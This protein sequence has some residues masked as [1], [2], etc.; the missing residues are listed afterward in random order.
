M[1]E[2]IPGKAVTIKFTMKTHLPDGSMKERPEETT[3]FIFGVERQPVSLETALE[4]TR[5][6]DRVHVHIPP[7]EIYGDH[8]P[9]LIHEIPKK[10][11][12]SSRIKKGQF[13][14]QM[15]KGSLVSFKVLEV[16]ADTVLADFNRPM[17]GISAAVDVE[18][19]SVREASQKE[20][21]A[22]IDAQNK[23]GIGCG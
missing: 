12:I 19:L 15:K 20:I 21:D 23:R 22:A 1:E 9:G 4:H 3:E 14:R 6:G 11:L 7:A 18:V 16:R 8:D 5:P 13:Y 2:I 10:G 17:A